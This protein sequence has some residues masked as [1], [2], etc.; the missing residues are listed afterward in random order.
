[1]IRRE[2]SC[3]ALSRIEIFNGASTSKPFQNSKI[4]W[5]L[6]FYFKDSYH[7]VMLGQTEMQLTHILL[8]R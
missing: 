7:H 1:M 6:V 5:S 3:G 2:G 8:P 4:I